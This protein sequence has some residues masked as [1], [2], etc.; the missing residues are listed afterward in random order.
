MS[1]GQLVEQLQ[2]VLH[3]KKLTLLND[4]QGE[5]LRIIL[6]EPRMTYEE[7]ADDLGLPV[8]TVK[9][10]VNLIWQKIEAAVVDQKVKRKNIHEIIDGL[11]SAYETIAPQPQID[12][13]FV[14]EKVP[15]LTAWHGRE[16]ELDAFHNAVAEHGVTFVCGETGIGKTSL[17]AR[18]MQELME[19]DETVIWQTIGVSS[20]ESEFQNLWDTI[21]SPVPCPGDAKRM[22]DQLFDWLDEQVMTVV[23]D[24]V[25]L[26]LKPNTVAVQLNPYLPHREVYGELI[27]R[28]GHQ[29]NKSRLVLVSQQPLSDVERLVRSGRDVATIALQGLSEAD[30]KGLFYA[31]GIKQ[32]WKAVYK[33]YNGHPSLMMNAI[34]VIND[35]YGGDVEGFIA[36]TLYIDEVDRTNYRSELERLSPAEMEVLRATALESLT[37]PDLAKRMLEQG[38]KLDDLMSALKRLHGMSFLEDTADKLAVNPFVRRVMRDIE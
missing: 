35:F 6:D 3:Q 32:S 10:A 8:T 30:A 14:L 22:A 20:G 1:S 37:R 17:V 19:E 16:L 21:M 15:V 34:N 23:L 24:R 27:K 12:K 36:N 33:A 18:A 13:D 9:P 28:F 11:L 4:Q 7:I 2:S 25:E 5:I 29:A 38:H 26:L 31:A